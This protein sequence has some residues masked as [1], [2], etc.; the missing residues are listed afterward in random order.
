MLLKE[1][2]I[3]ERNNPLT[4]SDHRAVSFTGQMQS[5][6]D[7]KKKQQQQQKKNQTPNS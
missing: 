2:A 1:Y 7:A 3:S 4:C 5:L 6:G